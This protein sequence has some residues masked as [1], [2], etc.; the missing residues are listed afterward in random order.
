MGP[1]RII[2]VA[3]PEAQQAAV[4][5]LRDLL[6]TAA[7]VQF[8]AEYYPDRQVYGAPQDHPQA[9]GYVRRDSELTR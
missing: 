5:G 4:L 3:S 6:D 8:M 1:H 9:P 2:I 7:R